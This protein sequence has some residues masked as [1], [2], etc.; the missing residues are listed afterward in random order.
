M[1]NKDKMLKVYFNSTDESVK[2]ANMGI[3]SVNKTL[4]TSDSIY[5]GYKKPIRNL[6]FELKTPNTNEGTLTVSKWNGSAWVATTMI[7]QTQ[8]FKKSNFILID[9]EEALENK[10]TVNGQE[11]Y[12]LKITISANSS[13][14]VFNGINLVFCSENDLMKREPAIKSF[15]PRELRSHILTLQASRDQILRQINNT[16]LH[17]YRSLDPLTGNPELIKAEDF[18]QFD[19]FHIDELNLCA[20]YL[21]LSILFNNR[22]DADESDMY[23]RKSAYYNSL[24]ES[25]YQRW[26]GMKLTLDLN[27]D[28]KEDD[29]EKNMSVARGSFTR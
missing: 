19:V 23:A 29:T 16:N 20:T 9:E 14:L 26:N 24:Y 21:A 6:F 10:H 3:D 7:D 28:G 4:L 8:G 5:I 17:I 18:N 25:E 1:A 13:A 2:C 22:S 27:D 12:W 15:Y 11:A